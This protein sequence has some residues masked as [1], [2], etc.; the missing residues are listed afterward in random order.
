MHISTDFRSQVVLQIAA[1]AAD[2]T[3]D[4]DCSRAH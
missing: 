1:A 2:Y 4:P 3:A